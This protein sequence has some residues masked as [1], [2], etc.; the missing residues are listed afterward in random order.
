M[1]GSARANRMAP[2]RRERPPHQPSTAD[3]WVSTVMRENDV[4]LEALLLDAALTGDVVA[5]LWARPEDSGRRV[6]RRIYDWAT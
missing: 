4:M 2:A 3:E 5:R 6:A 1:E